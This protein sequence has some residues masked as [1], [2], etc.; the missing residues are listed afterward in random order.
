V[1]SLV[2]P[3]NSETQTPLPT[4]WSKPLSPKKL[5]AVGFSGGCR[6]ALL[7]LRRGHTARH[8]YPGTIFNRVPEVN[9]ATC[10]RVAGSTAFR[11]AQNGPHSGVGPLRNPILVMCGHGDVLKGC[12]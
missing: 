2:A 12:E 7:L 1:N 10:A 4:S 11:I 5:R 8:V 6:S 3:T 9:N